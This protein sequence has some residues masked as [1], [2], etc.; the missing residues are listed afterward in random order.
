M[1]KICYW[2]SIYKCLY[3]IDFEW[4][5]KRMIQFFESIDIK[6]KTD[7]LSISPMFFFNITYN[8]YLLYYLIK[9]NLSTGSW[10]LMEYN[11]LMRS[12]GTSYKATTITSHHKLFQNIAWLIRIDAKLGLLDR[13]LLT[14]S[15]STRISN[16]IQ[17]LLN[18]D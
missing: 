5:Y 4:K 15:P 3:K 13:K 14:N 8:S 16:I 9:A 7:D 12:F 2:N 17:P 6:P 18:K 1:G 11:G 10:N